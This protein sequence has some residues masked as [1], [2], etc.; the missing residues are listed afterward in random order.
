M[1]GDRH[2]LEIEAFG[3]AE[4]LMI[5]VAITESGGRVVRRDVVV[6]AELTDLAAYVECLADIARLLA[7]K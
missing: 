1:D 6:G 7:R 4:N 2:D 3:L 5:E